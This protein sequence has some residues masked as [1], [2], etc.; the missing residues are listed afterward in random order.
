MGA[1]GL[2]F[3]LARAECRGAASVLALVD[4]ALLGSAPVC[5][6]ALG[7]AAG[8]DPFPGSWDPAVASLPV[9][10]TFGQ[11]IFLGSYL[12][13]VIPLAVARLESAIESARRTGGGPG[14]AGAVARAVGPGSAYTLGAIGLVA[15]ASGWAPAWWL[16]VPW[17]VA[18]A[19][20]LAVSAAPGRGG[21]RGWAVVVLLA[22]L[23]V[24]QVSVVVLSRAR[25]AFL[26]MLVGLSVTVLAALA[27]RR[28]VRTLTAAG[29]VLGA[30]LL[31][32]VLLNV[33]GS[34]LAPLGEVRILSRLSRLT[35]V[36]YA[37]PVWL[38]LKLW[39]AIVSG[40]GRQLRGDEVVPGTWPVA[41]SI[42]GY[43]PETQLLTLDQLARRQI[44][45]LRTGGV[46]WQGEYL[47]DRAHD[48][49]LDQLVTAG[50]VGAALWLTTAAVLLAVGLSRVREAAP[51][52]ETSL[53]LGCLGAVLA[54]L[55]EGAVGI[56]TPMPLAL[57][58]VSAALLGSRAW[59]QAVD[60]RGVASPAKPAR[61]WWW[62][63]ALAAGAL[64]ASLVA[65]LDTRWLLASLAYADG[66]RAHMAGRPAAAY[67]SFQ[68]SRELSPWLV[69]PAEAV[70]YTAIRLAAREST[71]SGRLGWLHE[72]ESAITDARERV[73][74][75]A[76]SWALAAQIA[77]AE[78]RAGERGKLAAS[79][80]AFARAARL[81]PWDSALL[82]Q[83]GW[84]LLE[85]GSAARARQVAERAVAISAR[86]P[87]WLPWA[88]LARSA[89]VLGDTA[90]AAHAA[91]EARRLAPPEA[92]N[93]LGEFVEAER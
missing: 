93:M 56:V 84:A 33:P 34:P 20:A 67:A 4:A 61:S 62:A 9:R 12:V 36:T 47:L 79:L 54:H 44:G 22:G 69:P 41:R 63:P 39:S 32:V 2:V 86:R 30:V 60:P 91:D 42:I 87:E 19:V 43:G 74:A 51:G 68:R 80:E 77:F 14:T 59:S 23:L 90:E 35:D 3:F 85:S 55:A 71:A 29:V 18:G 53:R 89:R 88:V 52:E 26:A 11:H 92:R 6:L 24:L 1:A 8:W 45:V 81:R 58:W 13:L 49:L 66:A 57:F 7:Q 72:G 40:W 5:L 28:A 64:L 46:G 76:S 25:G 82:A 10:S 21:A 31:L 75:S 78:A 50:L 17:G 37:S 15:L 48:A 83:W 65:W 38:R 73:P 70:A 16:L 27:R